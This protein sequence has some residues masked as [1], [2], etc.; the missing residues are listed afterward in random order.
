[1]KHEILHEGLLQ[2]IIAGRSPEDLSRLQRE[3][4]QIR[5]EADR[6]RVIKEAESMASDAQHWA[7]NLRAY[8]GR[9]FAALPALM[10][11]GL[12]GAI[13][14]PAGAAAGVAG[15]APAG[16]AFASAL[17]RGIGESERRHLENFAKKMRDV[18]EQARRMKVTKESA[19]SY[20]STDTANRE[21]TFADR[22]AFV[23]AEATEATAAALIERTATPA[24]VERPS[25]DHLAPDRRAREAKAR[26]L[27]RE[28]LGTARRA[29][30]FRGLGEAVYA[31]LPLDE[32][33]KEPH[34][35]TVLRETAEMASMLSDWELSQAGNELAEMTAII[36]AADPANAADAVS[37]AARDAST[38]LGAALAEVATSLEERVLDA[39]L[40][41]RARANELDELLEESADADPEL[42]ASRARRANR[43]HRPTLLE[44][45]FITT[46]RTLSEAAD[47]E[48]P[49]DIVLGEAVAQYTML[50]TLSAYGVLTVPDTGA[51]AVRIAARHS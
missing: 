39:V 11:G 47:R 35:D 32:H 30:F 5:S 33:E 6:E 48:V 3:V 16:A 10:A 42:A 25:G 31:A 46:T 21:R 26:A 43:R 40:A 38:E 49:R 23:M 44:S 50:E 24:A 45:L 37:A 36:A 19:M 8:L 9:N 13:A 20:M 12:G 27:G 1:M 15:A 2:R 4:R 51:L 29:A 7:D 28:E 41:A 17:P 22:R 18:A 14:G 34:R